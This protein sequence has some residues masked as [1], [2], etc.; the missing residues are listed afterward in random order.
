VLLYSSQAH[1][2]FKTLKTN[3]MKEFMYIFRNT[4]EAEEAYAKMSPKEME[5]DMKLWNEWMGKLAQSGKLVGGQPLLPH[6]KVVKAGKKITDGPYIEGKDVIGGYLIIKAASI[7]EAIDLSEG[8]PMY[9]SPAASV[10]VRE[11]MAMPGMQ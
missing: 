10:E 2:W 5:A 9:N 4:N 8:C 3:I 1:K 7:E 11:V 6:G